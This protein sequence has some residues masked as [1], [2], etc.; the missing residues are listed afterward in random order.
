MVSGYLII[1]ANSIDDAIK[2]ADAC[3]ALLLGGNAEVRSIMKID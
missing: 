2:L 1:R 3:P